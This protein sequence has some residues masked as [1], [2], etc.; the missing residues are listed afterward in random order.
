MSFKAENLS[1]LSYA[2]GFT[3]WHYRSEDTFEMIDDAG[4]F[5][6]AASHLRKG[7]FLFVNAGLNT[8]EGHGI[9]IVTDNDGQLVD[10]SNNT[11]L[12]MIDSD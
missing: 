9:L 1:V 12:G 4:Y 3:L 11:P 10:V 6:D 2:N 8:I 5:N 7:D